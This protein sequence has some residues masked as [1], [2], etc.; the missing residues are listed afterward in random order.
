MSANPHQ[1]FIQLLSVHEISVPKGY[2]IK[3]NPRLVPP[4]LLALLSFLF[5]VLE[6]RFDFT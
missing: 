5:V 3:E 1:D 2:D 6:L 4:G